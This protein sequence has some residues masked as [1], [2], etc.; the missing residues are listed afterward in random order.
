MV[1]WRETGAL[2]DAKGLDGGRQ[3]AVGRRRA[4]SEVLCLID[5]LRLT[6]WSLPHSERRFPIQNSF[7]RLPFGTGEEEGQSDAIPLT[8]PDFLFI[9]AP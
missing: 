6:S 3:E 8:M 5:C 9:V 4:L 1:T 7:L 2:G